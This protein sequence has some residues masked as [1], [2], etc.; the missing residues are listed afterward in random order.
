MKMTY[1][2]V[3]RVIVVNMGPMQVSCDHHFHLDEEAHGQEKM[4]VSCMRHGLR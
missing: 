1:R 4:E 2:A 3:G